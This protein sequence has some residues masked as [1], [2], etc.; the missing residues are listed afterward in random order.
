MTHDTHTRLGL[1]SLASFLAAALV[2]GCSSGSAGSTATATRPALDCGSLSI[3]D[4][5]SGRL[6]VPPGTH[7]TTSARLGAVSATLSGTTEIASL[8]LDQPDR[9][10]VV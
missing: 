7:V 4:R 8:P 1:L 10:S 9:K 2:G 5:S 6:A 3:V